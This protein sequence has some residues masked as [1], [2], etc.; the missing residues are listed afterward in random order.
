MDYSEAERRP[1]IVE[2][3]FG[4]GRREI[5]TVLPTNRGN[6]VSFTVSPDGRTLVWCQM[7]TV[8][9]ALLVEDFASLS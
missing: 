1:T 7:E 8:A 4:D 2:Y 3:R 6:F 9:D 5:F